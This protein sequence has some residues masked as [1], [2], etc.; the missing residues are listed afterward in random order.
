MTQPPDERL[1]RRLVEQFIDR[2]DIAEQIAHGSTR[3]VH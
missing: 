3:A 1:Q 2:G